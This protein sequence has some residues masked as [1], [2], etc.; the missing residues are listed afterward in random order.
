MPRAAVAHDQQIDTIAAADITSLRTERRLRR[1]GRTKGQ[2]TRP[3]RD[4]YRKQYDKQDKDTETT[5]QATLL[6]P[7]TRLLSG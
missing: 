7:G 3:N 1:D 4:Q 2:N 5:D 6:A